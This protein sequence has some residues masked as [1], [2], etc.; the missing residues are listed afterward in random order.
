MKAN[1]NRARRRASKDGKRNEMKL[2]TNE[3][4]N[5][6]QGINERDKA[7]P[8]CIPLTETFSADGKEIG[9]EMERKGFLF[10]EAFRN[11]F[12]LLRLTQTELLSTTKR[13]AQGKKRNAARNT[14][15]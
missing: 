2:K 7:E 11:S 14:R 9:K 1:Q 13:K 8:F 4:E 12:S 6:K 10:G 15:A 5:E 3:P